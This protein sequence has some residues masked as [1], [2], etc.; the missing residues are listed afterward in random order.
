VTI[1]EQNG[2][3]TENGVTLWEYPNDWCLLITQMINIVLV[4]QMTLVLK[5]SRGFCLLL[6]RGRQCH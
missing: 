4:I 6:W 3:R 2:N 5:I 1:R